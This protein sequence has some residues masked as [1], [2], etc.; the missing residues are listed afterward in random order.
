LYQTFLALRFGRGPKGTPA[1]MSEY[2]TPEE[3]TIG[4]S[5]DPDADREQAGPP[6]ESGEEPADTPE[7]EGQ[8]AEERDAQ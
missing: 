5:H 2:R 3:D 6:P 7:R 8:A 4:G 1:S